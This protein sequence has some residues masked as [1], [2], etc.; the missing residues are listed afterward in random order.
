MNRMMKRS[1]LSTADTTVRS[2][3]SSTS[4][5]SSKSMTSWTTSTARKAART[6]EITSTSCAMPIKVSALSPGNV[7]RS[8]PSSA[9]AWRRWRPRST[10]PAA[11]AVPRARSLDFSPSLVRGS[12][13]IAPIRRGANTMAR[14]RAAKPASISPSRA[15]RVQRF[16]PSTSGPAVCSTSNQVMP[17]GVE[18]PSWRFRR[19][20]GLIGA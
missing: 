16:V 19:R 3:P 18:W 2:E 14:P 5:S 1:T 12:R 13:T 7:A 4:S 15:N 17:F 20:D 9:M 8:E 10:T 6:S 11:A